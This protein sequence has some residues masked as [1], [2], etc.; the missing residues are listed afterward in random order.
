MDFLLNDLERKYK[1][2]AKEVLVNPHF[3]QVITVEER[4]LSPSDFGLHNAV[5]QTNGSLCFYDFEYAGWDDPAKTIA[6]FFARPK[7][8][9]PSE[10]FSVMKNRI[11]ELLPKRKIENLVRRLSLVA[12]MA[13]L[14]WCYICLNVFHPEDRKEE[15]WQNPSR[16]ISPLLPIL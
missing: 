10:L 4:I 15:N 9:A 7:H 1:E 11:L 8:K 12:R 3:N 13:N 16:S 14:K 5:L 2:L 6:D